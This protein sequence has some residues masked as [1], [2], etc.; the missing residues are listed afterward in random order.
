MSPICG[1]MSRNGGEVTNCINSM[2]SVLNHPNSIYSWLVSDGVPK[3]WNGGIESVLGQAMGQ[4]SFAIREQPSQPGLDCSGKLTVLY[5]GNLYNSHELKSKLASGHRLSAGGAAEVIAH[6]LEE[7]YRGELVAAVKQVATMIDGDYCL[8]ASDGNQV[9]I[10]RDMAGLRPVFYAEN[11][12]VVA[13]ASVKKA[14]W[15]IGLRNVKPVRAGISALFDKDGIIL[16][17]VCSLQTTG[18][19]V[20]IYDMPTAVD[21]YCALLSGAVE[22]RLQDLNKVGVLIS[23]GVDSCLMGKLVMDTATEG[24][25]EVTAY[26]VG[27]HGTADIEYAEHFARELGL[28]HKVRRI[29]QN[30]IESYIPKVAVA[31][32]ERDMVQIEAGVGIYAALEMASQDGVSAIFSGQ[33]PD[34]LWGGY[35]WYPQ[36]IAAEG[37]EGLLE[38]M[39]DD[40]G[41]GDIETFDRENR[42]A[43]AHGAEQIF[44]YCDTE[45]IKLAMSVSPRLKITSAE[46]KVGKHPHREAAERFGVPA[47]FAYRGKNAAQHST[48]VHETLD[49]IARKN[50]FTPE[51]AVRVGYN[52]EDVCPEK[53]AS[54]TRYG[55][56]YGEKELWQVPQHV[57]FFLDSIAY[58]NNLLNQAERQKIKRLVSK[59]GF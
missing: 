47:E 18:I 58:E 49:A 22:K 51:L 20:D 55:Y 34:E 30:E 52:S 57:Q 13:F 9:I 45:V 27:T 4:V 31:A 54:S 16:D 26:T 43:L 48:G 46:D 33:G 37:Y 23:G 6:L 10:L 12:D 42:I 50:G 24:G 17:D 41:R 15:K 53:L 59:A 32:E 2:L 39:W 28:K 36:V 29:C 5:E 40:L 11:G 7:R 21:G 35:T 1:V 38:R 8:A 19:E 14:L 25:I 44:P 56:R 3:R